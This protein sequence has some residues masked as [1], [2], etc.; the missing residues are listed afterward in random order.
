MPAAY[1]L[2]RVSHQG[3]QS[4]SY[5]TIP[6]PGYRQSRVTPV[7]D[8]HSKTPLTVGATRHVL[9]VANCTRRNQDGLVSGTT[10]TA[11]T[12]HPASVELQCPPWEAVAKG[13]R[14][15]ARHNRY[16]LCQHIHAHRV[17]ETEKGEKRKTLSRD[18][19]I[20]R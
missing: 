3:R 9:A 17:W 7:E 15:R 18:R 13:R 11:R 5:A 20:L 14:C 6:H 8:G 12:R 10:M 2:T 16:I 4:T 19:R 1:P